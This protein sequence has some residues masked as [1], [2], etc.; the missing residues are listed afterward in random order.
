[1]AV[2]ERQKGQVPLGFLG[3]RVEWVPGVGGQR[4]ITS[5]DKVSSA[6]EDFEKG[7]WSESKQERKRRQGRGKALQDYGQWNW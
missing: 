1:M 7:E 3:C 4:R 5:V 2:Q 6:R